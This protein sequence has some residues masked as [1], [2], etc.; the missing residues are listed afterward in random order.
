MGGAALTVSATPAER[1]R[2][3]ATFLPVIQILRGLAALLVVLFHAR[4]ILVSHGQGQGV[5]DL[6]TGGDIGVDIFF[7]VSGFIMMHIQPRYA[8]QRLAGAARFL[9]KGVERVIPPYW[10]YTLLV[11]AAFTLLPSLSQGRHRT[12]CAHSC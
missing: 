6:F 11:L 12:S 1:W 9:G 10:I 4:Q 3:A 2:E 5:L 8:G 7:V